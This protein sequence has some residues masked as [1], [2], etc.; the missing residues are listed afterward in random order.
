MSATLPGPKTDL[1]EP[2]GDTSRYWTAGELNKL[3][4]YI[5]ENA[6]GDQALVLA[7]G[8]STA[9]TL[10]D[11]MMLLDSVVNVKDP[12]FAGG[13]KGDGVTDDTAAIQAALDSLTTG[14]AG[15]TVVFSP[16]TYI[17][18]SLTVT[19]AFY[20]NGFGDQGVKLHGPGATLKGRA[21][22]TKILSIGTGAKYVNGISIEGL[23]FDMASMANAATTYGLYITQ[24]YNAAIKNVY[25]INEPT[26][27]YALYFDTHVYTYLVENLSAIRTDSNSGRVKIQGLNNST[28]MDSTITFQSCNLGQVVIDN[29]FS[30]AFLKPTMQGA[31]DHF[32]LSN[33][34]AI[35]VLGGDLEGTDGH[36]YN[37]G[38]NVRYVTSIGNSPGGYTNSTYSTGVAL[39]SNLNDRP[40]DSIG[41]IGTYVRQAGAAST[42]AA[43]ATPQQIYIFRDSPNS[44]GYS[45]SAA[46]FMVFGDD[47]ANGFCD[48]VEY[49]HQQTPYVIRSRSTY[50]APSAR[51]YTYS[52]GQ[53]ALM[54]AIAAPLNAANVS[55]MVL[56]EFLGN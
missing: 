38:A 19:K 11:S 27:G 16:G 7:T 3:R 28:D 2:S 30:I 12:R 36:V 55:V 14:S 45:H 23:S 46:R 5:A 35:T 52:S 25:V 6:L 20:T 9:R 13:A 51:T 24:S 33:C 50:G 31:L 26:A 15:G 49:V 48:E 18:G 39:Q 22:D 54:L 42:I 34:Q 41:S 56:G 4:D 21:S 37:F 32:V 40:I 53:I 1:F 29:A 43:A 17:A 47:G 44:V 8:S 10:A